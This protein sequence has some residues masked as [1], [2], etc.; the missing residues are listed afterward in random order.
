MAVKTVVTHVCDLCNSVIDSIRDATTVYVYK[1][2][3]DG[4]CEKTPAHVCSECKD[5]LLDAWGAYCR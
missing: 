1:K 2:M 3:A 5:K 4:E